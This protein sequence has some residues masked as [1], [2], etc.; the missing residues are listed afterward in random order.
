MGYQSLIPFCRF[1]VFRSS[2]SFINYFVMLDYIMVVVPFMVCLSGFSLNM[3]QEN[4]DSLLIKAARLGKHDLVE[5]LLHLG[6]AV[7]ARNKSDIYE[8]IMLA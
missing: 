7:E 8:I 3:K 1:F 2:E 4:G 5:A 6:A